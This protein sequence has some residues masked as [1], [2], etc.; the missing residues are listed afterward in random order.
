MIPDVFLHERFPDE[1]YATV[2]ITRKQ[3]RFWPAVVTD[4]AA[5]SRTAPVTRRRRAFGVV[6]AGIIVYV[7][8]HIA[9]VAASE[10]S[11]QLRDPLYG[12]KE[13]QLRRLEQCLPAGSP[14]VI[15][16]GTSRP[17]C[18]FDAGRTQELLTERIG[19]P[20]VVYNWGIPAAGPVMDLIHLKRM[21][22]D[23]H[24]PSLLLLEIFPACFASSAGESIDVMGLDG[25][26]F[27]W[28]ELDQVGAYDYPTKSLRTERQA[29]L[30]APWYALR[31]Q[32][33]GR[34]LPSTLPQHLRLRNM[35]HPRTDRNG[36]CPTEID[37]LSEEERAGA[38][39][40]VKEEFR[41][42][43]TSEALDEGPVRAFRDMLALARQEKIPVSLVWMPEEKDFHKLY[44]PAFI[45]AI[46]R[47]L[48]DLAAEYGCHIHDAHEWMHDTAFADGYHLLR[49]SA[50]SFT[51]RLARET[52]EPFFL[53]SAP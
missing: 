38:F 7:T 44:R 51:E 17:M 49:S 33:M 8:S 29:V 46:R 18:G 36:W 37:Q 19:R 22:R 14:E 1:G 23:G 15:F 45:A 9:L 27:D 24:K 53:D 10:F 16:L 47:F 26:R 21:L 25:S 39:S 48:H 52:I 20:I 42:L 5:P 30:I 12:T 11:R 35:C 32:L 41:H 34:L 4:T 6:T 40:R 28:S 31:Y 43:S 3:L 13:L 2:G 50:R